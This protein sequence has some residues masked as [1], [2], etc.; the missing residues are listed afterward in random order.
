MDNEPFN[1]LLDLEDFNEIYASIYGE[2]NPDDADEADSVFGTEGTSVDEAILGL[3]SADYSKSTGRITPAPA[4]VEETGE[5]M[6]EEELFAKA[7]DSYAAEQRWNAPQ[8]K[9]A[10]EPPAAEDISFD[11]RFNIDRDAKGRQRRGFSYNGKRVSAGQDPNY[12]PHEN[13]QYEE[14]KASYTEYD[15]GAL[16]RLFSEGGAAPEEP[17][18]AKKRFGFFKRKEKQPEPPPFEGVDMPSMQSEDEADSIVEPESA[19]TPEPE[20]DYTPEE[21]PD[22][23]P[24]TEQDFLL[25]EDEESGPLEESELPAEKEADSRMGKFRLR[26]QHFTKE[27]DELTPEEEASFAQ[28]TGDEESPASFGKFLT[29]RLAGVILRLR[30]NV[31][32]ISNAGV[33]AEED[34]DLGDEL[35]VMAASN[36]YSAQIYSLRIRTRMATILWLL[37]AYLSLGLP[38]PG[39]MQYLPV[40]VAACMALQLTIMILALDH[41]TNAITNLFRK[42]FGADALAVISCL[43]TIF[44]GAAVLNARNVYQHVPYFAVSSFS[45]LGIMFASLLSARGL[46]KALRVPAIGK[47]VYC[48]TA[49]TNLTGQDIT[50]LKS[51]RPTT[52]FV[53][54]IEE[55][56]IDETAFRKLSPLVFLA[57]L[58]LSI[59]AV[60]V[61]RSPANILYFFSSVLAPA[62]PF[63]ALLG[64]ALP[65]FVG[66]NRIFGS[67]A[68]LAGWSGISDIGNSKNLIVTDRDIFP[69]ENIEIENVRIFADYDADKVITYAGSLI[70]ASKCGLAPAFSK[71]MLENECTPVRIDNLAF[72]AGGGIKGMAEGH[73][74]LCGGSDVMRLMNVRIPYRLVSPTTVLLAIDGVLYGIFNIKYTPDPKVRKALVSLMRS[75]RHPIFA[76]RDFNI[77][78]EFIRDCFD[79]AT[80]GYDFPPYTE[81][82]PISEAKPS[83]DSLISAVVCREGLGPLTD[84]ADTGRSIFV[85]SRANTLISVAASV[86]GMLFSFIRLT[87]YGSTGVGGMLLMMILFALP[88]LVLGLFT[89]SVN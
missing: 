30:G 87:V 4:V 83:E 61:K 9:A 17:A 5:T 24:E 23:T 31:P 15:D 84:V 47:Q 3:S 85:V 86:I 82:F 81:R 29:A 79:V 63:T 22:Y 37:L 74:V 38:I 26:F 71:L 2:I 19:Y 1:N 34:E 36:Y 42:K 14:L 7:E 77:T 70:L 43:L 21:E 68:A 73:T 76:I 49:E 60:A 66:S 89:T 56:P 41:V 50:I 75:N 48:V 28:E 58:V 20:T 8:A 33:M 65:F 16:D 39:M 55:A 18:P 13:P 54:R 6:P 25:Q 32:F 78:P 51:A 45:L 44:D 35:P 52:G 59:V 62:V 10:P 64:F 80:D 40:K 53:R 57:S 11:P 88:V 72:L 69:A 46:R 27:A 67:G 12:K